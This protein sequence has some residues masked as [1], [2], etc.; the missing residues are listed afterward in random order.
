M[1]LFRLGDFTL[2]SG[3]ASPF[4]IDCDALSD[5][6]WAAVAAML[7]E[8]L[9]P[10]YSVDGVP[11]GG[12]KLAEA[13]RK[14][15]RRGGGKHLIVDDV[16]T[17]G[18][19]IARWRQRYPGCQVIGAVLFARGP[20]PSWVTPLFRMAEP[21]QER[22]RCHHYNAVAGEDGY[23]KCPSCGRTDGTKE[24]CGICSLQFCDCA[25]LNL[26]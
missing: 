23:L 2:S 20:A 22:A 5:E 12:L 11:R 6:D 16:L 13:M 14:Y 7:A 21:P 10:F 19:S 18:G 25:A 3:E 9:P 24:L 15:V 17:T 1:N 4:K 8:Q 26:R